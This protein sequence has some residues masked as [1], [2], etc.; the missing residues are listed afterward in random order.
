VNDFFNPQEC[1]EKSTMTQ[2]VVV[3]RGSLPGVTPL[4]LQDLSSRSTEHSVENQLV[5]SQVQISFFLPISRQPS[6][7]V[8]W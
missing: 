6:I 4:E 2:V 3:V 5:L 8:A 7:T 1:L